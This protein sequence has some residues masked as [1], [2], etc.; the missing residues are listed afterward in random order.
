MFA[1]ATTLISISVFV[2]AAVFLADSG[3]SGFTWQPIINLGGIGLVLAWVLWKLEPRM[4]GLEAAI[5][6][7]TRANLVMIIEIKRTSEEAKKAAQEM[8]DEIDQAAKLR[9]GD[10]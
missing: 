1:I 5:E 6:R 2:S 10:D 3:G 8:I 7:N 4:R 9:G